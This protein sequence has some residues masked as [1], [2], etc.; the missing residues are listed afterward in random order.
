MST[1]L[2]ICPT[3][4]L[5]FPT[6]HRSLPHPQAHSK[7][8]L[9][10]KSC[11][12]RVEGQQNR[13]FSQLVSVQGWIWGQTPPSSSPLCVYSSIPPTQ[14]FSPCLFFIERKAET[15]RVCF[16]PLGQVSAFKAQ[17]L[18]NRE[19]SFRK[20]RGWSLGH[21]RGVEGREA[22][23]AGS[24]CVCHVWMFSSFKLVWQSVSCQSNSQK[25]ILL[26]WRKAFLDN[27]CP[28]EFSE[29]FFF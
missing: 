17:V 25:N 9:Q 1:T 7:L 4:F 2:W 16:S 5:P 6:L 10:R 3:T 27:I 8:L 12:S 21:E 15:C 18:L 28:S 29:T 23:T 20:T 26:C 14:L 22:D 24:G 13:L 11:W 19:S